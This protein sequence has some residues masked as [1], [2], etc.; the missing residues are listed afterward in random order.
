MV[1][2]ISND[3]DTKL[4]ALLNDKGLI[5]YSRYV[6]DILIIFNKKVDINDIKKL[7][8]KLIQDVFEKS[9]VKINENKTVY[10]Y[11]NS[12]GSFNYLGYCFKQNNKANYIKNKSI[13]K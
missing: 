5:H 1:E 13:F 12:Q 10:L 11:K 7:L 2:I 8:K 3:F 4:C 6:D 9:N